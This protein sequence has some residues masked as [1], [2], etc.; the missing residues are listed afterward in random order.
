MVNLNYVP[1]VIVVDIT[2]LT[3]TEWLMKRKHGIGGSEVACIFNSSSWL[4]KRE[5]YLNKL[6][7]TIRKGE[8]EADCDFT[9]RFILEYGNAVEDIAAQLFAAKTK[10]RVY[11]DNHMYQH[12]LYPFM[13]GDFDR[14]CETP[15]GVIEGL[16]LKSTNRANLH[17]WRSGVLGVDGMCPIQYE[18]QVRHYMAVKN[19]DRWHI[20]CLYGNSPNE[21]FHII[22]NRDLDIEEQIIIGEN[23]FWNNN[24]LT[25]TPPPLS[26]ISNEALTRIREQYLPAAD[27]AQPIKNFG[28]DME[29]LAKKYLAAKAEYDKVDEE[30]TLKKGALNAVVSE[31]QEILGPVCEATIQSANEDRIYALTYKPQ[32]TY[33]IN[34]EAIKASYPELYDLC[35]TENPEGKRP[36]TLKEM[37]KEA[38][39]KK[40]A[41]KN[42]KKK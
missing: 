33:S 40:Q 20:F 15:R 42:K 32:T 36:F 26:R 3:R 9:D 11:N 2:K 25:R 16:E 8:D 31:L 27:I 4:T 21:Y 14:M 1:N 37:D 7:K 28:M 23:D 29:E 30:L 22:V 18:Y 41:Y 17:K 5:L 6:S 34:R 12:P 13:I 38:Y 35:V 19:I 24:V 39:N 10:Y